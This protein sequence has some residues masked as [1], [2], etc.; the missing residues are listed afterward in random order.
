MAACRSPQELLRICPFERP[1]PGNLC[2]MYVGDGAHPKQIRIKEV[3]PKSSKSPIQK[4]GRNM[5]GLLGGGFKDFFIFTPKIGEDSH[6][7]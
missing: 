5:K 1:K 4:A 2:G 3:S 7:D 6:F